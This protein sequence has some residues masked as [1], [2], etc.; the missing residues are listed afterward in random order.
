MDGDVSACLSIHLSYAVSERDGESWPRVV[1]RMV[2]CCTLWCVQGSLSCVVYV[3]VYISL[4]VLGGGDEIEV[5]VCDLTHQPH[6]INPT[7][8]SPLPTHCAPLIAVISVATS[9]NPLP[10]LYQIL[11]DHSRR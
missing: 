8:H 11:N 1:R 4:C 9:I 7:T 6:H 5:S 2:G 3:Y 10:S